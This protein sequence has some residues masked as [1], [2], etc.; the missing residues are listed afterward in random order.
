MYVEEKNKLNKK[1]SSLPS[2]VRLSTE[3]LDFLKAFTNF[4]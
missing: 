4:P 3:E 2:T 1:T